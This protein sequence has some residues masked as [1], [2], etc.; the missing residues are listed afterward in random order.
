MCV[1]P[2][3]VLPVSFRDRAVHPTLRRHPAAAEAELLFE[4][5]FWISFHAKTPS[6]LLGQKPSDTKTIFVRLL[7]LLGGGQPR[8]S[9]EDGCGHDLA[10]LKAEGRFAALPVVA[11][12]GMRLGSTVATVV[13]P[14]WGLQGFAHKLASN[15]PPGDRLTSAPS[16]TNIA[17][18]PTMHASFAGFW[19]REF[20]SP[21]SRHFRRNG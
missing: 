12:R 8:Q 15:L 17:P 20:C 9:G 21:S 1:A 16:R 10:L 7:S 18:C 14:T 11:S 2:I 4:D 6:P 19:P 5:H 13:F 3:A